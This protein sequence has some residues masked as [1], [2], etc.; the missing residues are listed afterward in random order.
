MNKKYKTP[1][2]EVIQIFLEEGIASGSAFARPQN[3]SNQII[4]EWEQDETETK[5]ID[6]F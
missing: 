6:W 1:R 5:N 2:I 3:G 4:E